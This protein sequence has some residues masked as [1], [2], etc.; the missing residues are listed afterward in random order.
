MVGAKPSIS[1]LRKKKRS[2][3]EI[4]HCACMAGQEI[5]RFRDSGNS[6]E[7]SQE[8]FT[9]VPLIHT[10]VL[11]AMR[12]LQSFVLN[13]VYSTRV[14]Y[15]MASV[16]SLRAALAQQGEL[17]ANMKKENPN[18]K[19]VIADEVAK[20]NAL[21]DQLKALVQP[22]VE[23]KKKSELLR[24]SVEEILV[25]RF[26]VVPSF[27]IYGGIGGLYDLGPPGCALRDNIV[28]VW[29][30]HFI[31]KENMLEVSCSSLTPEP[32]LKTSGHVDRFTDLMVR[33]LDSEKNESFRADK[34]LQEHIEK[35][36]DDVDLTEEKRT[37]L[38]AIFSKS[39][40]YEANELHEIFQKLDVKS[41]AGGKL[42]EPFP[43]NLMFETQ[44]GPSGK[45]KGYMRPETAQGIFTNFKRLLKFNNE[46]MPFAS[47][48][49]GPAYRNEISPRSGLLR[50]R[51][52]T[53][54][55]IEH[56]VHKDRKDH[57][58]FVNVKDVEMSLLPR[59][60][61]GLGDDE[62]NTNKMTI[63][64][65]VNSKVVGNETL[66]Y[67]M[68]RTQL[69]LLRI[70]IHADKL[71]FRQHKSNEMAHYA[72]D[73]W[74]AEIKSSYG[75]VECVGH[76]DRSCYDLEAHSKVT[77]VELNAQIVYDEPKLVKELKCKINKGKVGPMYKKDA[78]KV[79]EYLSSLSVDDAFKFQ[80]ELA[81]NGTASFTLCTGEK[82]EVTPDIVSFEMVESKVTNEKYIP[83][84]IEPSFGI[85]RIL[86]SLL[87]H[88]YCVREEEKE[89]RRILSFKPVVAPIKASVLPLSPNAEFK[90]FVS[91]ISDALVD[92]NLSVNADTSS[93]AIGRRY[94]RADELG[95]PFGI[96]I[97]FDTLK[98]RTVTV[99]DRDT[100]TQVRVSVDE[101][102]DLVERL[103][104]ERTS[105][106]EVYN[107]YPK[108][109]AQESTA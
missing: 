68:A 40:D 91:L 71:R 99:R 69:F 30:N 73:C 103:C 1:I 2:F 93:A 42:S 21:K 72:S 41:P 90:P 89:Q 78:S 100:L 64:E 54:A 8:N 25:Q 50:V 16:E 35:L 58:K 83:A 27:E 95:I 31:L 70:G 109:F 62:G 5:R 45:Q 102:A 92:R 7:N 86:Y 85:G 26:F 43:F 96:T 108:F 56:F 66:G 84:V 49:I 22:D 74:D 29:K 63:G 32:V 57:A 61:Q 15:S 37:E 55:E 52:F 60:R 6:Q 33:D 87:E 17:I 12:K 47:A 10:S 53:L 18:N 104:R 51:E 94:S 3:L 88:S 77:K 48:Q 75:W 19:K 44:I 105:W 107:T 76:A 101:V 9:T 46:R 79:I 11:L 67:F 13:S 80:N 82:F 4:L 14:S 39:D 28:A 23:A 59:E 97:D 36:L 81:K 38:K 24:Q 34:L 20:L 106:Q 98:N 65:A